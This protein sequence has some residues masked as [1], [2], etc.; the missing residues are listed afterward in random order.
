MILFSAISH[1][2]CMGAYQWHRGFTAANDALFPRN[3]E[4]FQDL[5]MHG[6]VWAAC[7]TSGE[8]LAQA[9]ANFDEQSL[10]CEIGGLMV[11]KQAQGMGLGATIMRLA[12]AHA[13]VEEDILSIDGA[14]VVAHVLKSNPEP[15]KIITDKLLFKLAKTV[16]IPGDALPGLRADPDGII[17]GDE[18][19]I[20]LPESLESLAQWAQGWNDSLNGDG[21]A[22]IDL[23]DG[24]SMDLWA[25]ALRDIASRY[26]V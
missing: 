20:S 5:V 17:R 6:S 25:E 10:E 4:Q 3:E 8:Y 18:F 26:P 7:A 22:L 19:E 16:E 9:Y 15:R 24:V 21:Q 13:L 1:D 23:R 2:D 14:R 12:L 11:A